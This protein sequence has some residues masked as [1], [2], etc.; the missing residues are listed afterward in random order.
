MAQ[1]PAG[2]SAAGLWGRGRLTAALGRSKVLQHLPRHPPQ[3]PMPGDPDVSLEGPTQMDP[4]DGNLLDVPL[5]QTP[6][7]GSI[8]DRPP[9]VDPTIDPY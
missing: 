5:G 7:D 8:L 1:P 9:L 2:P 6:S 3:I 4:L